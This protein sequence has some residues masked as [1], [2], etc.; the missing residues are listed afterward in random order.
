[1][2]RVIFHSANEVVPLAVNWKPESTPTVGVVIG[3]HG[4][5]KVDW[6]TEW[7]FAWNW[8]VTVSPSEALLI[9]DGLKARAPP[10]PTVTRWS[11]AKTTEENR[12][13]ARTEKSIL[14]VN[15]SG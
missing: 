12:A 10:A 11:A 4:S 9:Q 2:L 3:T 7:F 6:V 15:E 1:M 5:A 14:F 8:K 13:V